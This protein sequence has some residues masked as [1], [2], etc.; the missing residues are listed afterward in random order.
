MSLQISFPLQ[1]MGNRVV[2]HVYSGVA[3]GLNDPHW[4][5]RQIG[6]KSKLANAGPLLQPPDCVFV[7]AQG[8]GIVRVEPGTVQDV[9]LDQLGPRLFTIGQIPLIR[10]RHDTASPVRETTRDSGSK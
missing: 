10:C 3:Q 6:S 5:P 2:C 4:I 1:Y 8:V 7:L 9:I